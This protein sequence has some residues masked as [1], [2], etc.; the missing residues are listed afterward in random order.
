[1]LGMALFPICA[2]YGPSPC[3]DALSGSVGLGEGSC[4]PFRLI[5][6]RRWRYQYN[7]PQ[8][9]K[10]PA[11]PPTMPP[12]IALSNFVIAAEVGVSLPE[13]VVDE[14]GSAEEEEEAEV[15]DVAFCEV[16]VDLMIDDVGEGIAVD[17]VRSGISYEHHKMKNNRTTY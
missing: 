13:G 9:K 4:C 7:R 6:L 2:M 11:R 17:S 3:Q 8:S 16:L 1:M 5:F 14:D 10:R 15:V 12:P